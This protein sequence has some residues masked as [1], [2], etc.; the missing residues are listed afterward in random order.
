M[1]SQL[2]VAAAQSPQSPLFSLVPMLIIFGIFYVIWFMPIRKK[3]KQLRSFV[4][5][6]S[7]GNKVVT[8]G[9]IYGEVAKVDEQTLLLKV[10]DNVKIKIS[11]S[12]IAGPEQ[13]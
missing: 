10:S 7:K 13:G 8:H 9:G 6:L 2:I 4:D 11:K 12:A 5:T 1:I 3:Q